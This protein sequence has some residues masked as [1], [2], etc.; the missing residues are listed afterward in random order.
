MLRQL[1]QFTVVHHLVMVIS[2]FI[3]VNHLSVPFQLRVRLMPH[4]LRAHL[5][6]GLLVVIPVL[7]APFS[8]HR[9]L[10]REVALSAEIWV[11]S[12]GIPR[13]SGGSS[14]QR[15]QQPLTSAPVTSPPAQPAR[16]GAHSARGRPRGGGQSGGGH[17]H[18][19]ALPAI[20][21]VI[22]SDAVITDPGIFGH[23]GGY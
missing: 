17:T 15:S 13:L 23:G 16:G 4:Q 10:Q 7:G 9:H 14:Q 1:A 19:Y 22:A 20:S 8:P 3:R 18:F 5:C 6:R 2:V 21:D 12:R 11:I